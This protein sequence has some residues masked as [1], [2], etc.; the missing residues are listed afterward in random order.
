MS[1]VCSFSF[2]GARI[3]LSATRMCFASCAVGIG[4]GVGISVCRAVLCR[5]VPCRLGGGGKEALCR[6]VPS[7]PTQQ[8]PL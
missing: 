5:A 8:D 3:T 1:R 7:V 4:G 6:A 2:E